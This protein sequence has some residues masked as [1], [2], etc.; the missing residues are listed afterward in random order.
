MIEGELLEDK[1]GVP[2]FMVVQVRLL[3]AVLLAVPE[4]VIL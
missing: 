1:V 3:E 4:E 2:L